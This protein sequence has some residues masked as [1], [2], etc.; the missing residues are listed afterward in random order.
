METKMLSSGE[1]TGEAEISLRP[2]TE[3]ETVYS[4][5]GTSTAK[6]APQNQ[7]TDLRPPIPTLVLVYRC[8]ETKADRHTTR[9]DSDWH[10]VITTMQERALMLD[11]DQQSWAHACTKLGRASA[12]ICALL[13][14]NRLARE[15]MGPVDNPRAYFNGLIRRG[16]TDRLDMAGSLQRIA[17]HRG[18]GNNTENIAERHVRISQQS[19]RSLGM[20]G[21]HHRKNLDD[22]IPSK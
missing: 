7:E 8:L 3:T 11:I 2:Y 14:E 19:Q 6:P 9:P 17:R 1:T 21:G 13:L 16:T 5:N 15:D 20:E 12:A 4:I 18:Q 10:H 22:K